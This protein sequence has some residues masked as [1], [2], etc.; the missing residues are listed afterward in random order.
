MTEKYHARATRR[1]PHARTSPIRTAVADVLA[2][3]EGVAALAT[4]ME[5]ALLGAPYR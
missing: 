5:N 3:M 4:A 1:C 2:H